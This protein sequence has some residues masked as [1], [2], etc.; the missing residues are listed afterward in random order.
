M[1]GAA[2]HSYGAATVGSHL[3]QL[4]KGSHHTLEGLL[5]AVAGVVGPLVVV[6]GAGLR[7]YHIAAH[8][9]ADLQIIGKDL[10]AVLHFYLI[11]VDGVK[12][13]A[14]QRDYLA[15]F[16]ECPAD[17]LGTLGC[18]GAGGLGHIGVSLIADHL[19]AVDAQLAKPLQDRLGAG[20][21]QIVGTDT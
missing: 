8:S 5:R 2:F 1:T 9:L 6:A 7:A 15:G 14:H 4:G 18:D 16:S 17:L 10:Q 13:S 19:Y 12:V 3:T 11:L 21:A 20:N